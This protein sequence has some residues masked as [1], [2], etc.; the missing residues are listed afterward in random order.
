MLDS[1]P[2]DLLELIVFRLCLLTA[3]DVGALKQ[4]CR[5]LNSILTSEYDNM[6]HHALGGLQHCLDSLN[7]AATFYALK[8]Y[9]ADPKTDEGRALRVA[10][11][12]RHDGLFDWLFAN[13]HLRASTFRDYFSVLNF[14]LEIGNDRAF[15]R[16]FNSVGP[17]PQQV[18]PDQALA[19]VHFIEDGQPPQMVT[20]LTVN[21]LQTC[22]ADSMLTYDLALAFLE[23]FPPEKVL[24]AVPFEL[25]LDEP[26]FNVRICIQYAA[27]ENR[28]STARRLTDLLAR[29]LS[30]KSRTELAYA[31]AGVGRLDLAEVAAPHPAV[32]EFVIAPSTP[33]EILDHVS[34]QS[35]P[36]QYAVKSVVLQHTP[37]EDLIEMLKHKDFIELKRPDLYA[38]FSEALSRSDAEV[39]AVLTALV[40]GLEGDARKEIDSTI[41]ELVRLRA[42]G[43]MVVVLEDIAEGD[44]NRGLFYYLK[45][46]SKSADRWLEF[47]HAIKY[48]SA[49]ETLLLKKRRVPLVH[50]HEC[51]S[52]GM[53]FFGAPESVVEILAGVPNCN[54]SYEAYRLGQESWRTMKAPDCNTMLSVFRKAKVFGAR[55][56]STFGEIHEKVV[57]WAH[58]TS[59]A[60]LDLK[61]TSPSIS[62]LRLRVFTEV[63]LRSLDK[64]PDELVVELVVEMESYTFDYDSGIR[65]PPRFVPKL[66]AA[67]LDPRNLKKVGISRFVHRAKTLDELEFCI[68]GVWTDPQ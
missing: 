60:L 3:E 23:S 47:A 26:A 67:G 68:S 37:T 55:P 51:N 16:I 58:E 33:A 15:L 20:A 38:I 4:V 13:G 45:H 24:N 21:I 46:Y 2:Y 25:H 49:M 30:P 64:C 53:G 66:I 62:S 1:L 10:I 50:M 35:Y 22:T 5:G 7:P 6:R 34:A 27:E 44:A 8:H 39:R 61:G 32:F 28:E 54:F 17:H 9:G 63:M 11:R 12:T 36:F 42:R 59:E 29:G 57:A 65:L 19:L 48:Y 43:T 14:C 18:H 52:Y 31:L 40:E 56:L 41:D